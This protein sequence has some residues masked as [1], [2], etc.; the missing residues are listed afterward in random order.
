V[1][2]CPNNKKWRAAFALIFQGIP[3]EILYSM[4]G[5]RHGIAHAQ[6]HA[7]AN[8]CVPLIML[9]RGHFI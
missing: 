3:Y 1:N 4:I 5:E 6:Q 2:A 9:A 7:R 8:I